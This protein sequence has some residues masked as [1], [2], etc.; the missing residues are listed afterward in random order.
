[1]KYEAPLGTYAS[2][3]P[4]VP[5]AYEKDSVTFGGWYLNPQCTGEEYKLE[6]HTMP[7]GNVLLYAKW[8]PV[9]HT[10][11]FRLMESSKD[12][13]TPKNA[14]A[15][16]FQVPHGS[17]IDREYA[18]ANLTAEAMNAAKPN[19][20]YKFVVWY[21]YNK[22][23][24]KKYFDPSMQVR[25]DM[26]LY[27]EWSSDT[28]KEYTVQFVL[29]AD[30]NTKVA[31]DLTGSGLA[32]TTKTFN[33]KG[34]TELFTDY[35]EGYFPTVKSQ[36]L[37]LDI[38]NDNLVITFEY[39]QA[40]EVPYTVKY[41]N[42]ETGTSE[43]DG[44]TVP[45]KVV[46]DN[47]KA[48]V[49]E[50]FKV[51]SGYMPDAYQKRLVVTVDGENILYFYYTKDDQ[52]AYYKI[53]HYTEL[54]TAADGTTNWT[55]YRTSEA[56]GDIGTRYTASPLTIRGYEYVR[57]EYVSNG[58]AI[59]ADQ[60]TDDGAK[61]PVGGL[62]INLYYVRSEYPYQV[63]YLEKGTNNV[64]HEP[65][66]GTGEYGEVISES[67]IEIP[68][69]VALDPT[70]K[71]LDIQIEEDDVAKVNIIT[72]YYELALTDLTISK[73]GCA[74]I[75][76]HQSFIFTVTGEGL[77]PAGL[78]VVVTGNGSVTIKGLKVGT[79]YTITEDTGWSW[80]YTPKAKDGKTAEPAQDIELQAEVNGYKNT[81]TFNNSRTQDKW[82][83]GCSWA[84]NNWAFGKKK[85]D[86]NPDGE[87]N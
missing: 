46:S 15:A 41:I 35:Q 78:K 59:P 74:N 8:V 44:V 81:V 60:I 29:K 39:V 37:V 58:V 76:E 2:Y 83:N 65:K 9:T 55:V 11:E 7:A 4:A 50:T 3:R 42:T 17:T 13:Y 53:T 32:G 14:A 21:Y 34:G 22:D 54:S 40:E 67:A 70:S 84:E 25:E 73:S 1:M 33:A 27:G 20:A 87:T 68:N 86:K 18:A 19:G 85:T 79:T 61:L 52:H 47:R 49:T 77:P 71:T 62:E 45:D 69:Y 38:E 12:I 64:L 82:L 63:R 26:T 56:P 28:L 80:R 23:G 72:F 5:A 16:S 6:S 66:D 43:F 57:T 30:H 31:P 24:V 51:I 75:D 48:V 36:S 10:V